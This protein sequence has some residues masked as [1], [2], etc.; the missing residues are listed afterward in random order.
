MPVRRGLAYVGEHDHS[1]AMIAAQEHVAITSTNFFQHIPTFTTSISA[2]SSRQSSYSLHRLHKQV[3]AQSK[4]S[5]HLYKAAHT[6][7]V[8]LSRWTYLS[9]CSRSAAGW[10]AHLLLAVLW[11]R[12]ISLVSRS[13]RRRRSHDSVPS[14]TLLPHVSL[15][16]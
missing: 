7:V 5:V 13:W 16:H 1:V 2:P 14:A 11:C 15:F 12:S 10:K 6:Q 4:T 9:G 3:C 8:P